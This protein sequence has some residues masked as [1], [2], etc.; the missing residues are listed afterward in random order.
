MKLFIYLT[1]LWNEQQ[2][3]FNTKTINT[4]VSGSN[5]WNILQNKTRY[6]YLIIQCY[7]RIALSSFKLNFKFSSAFCNSEIVRRS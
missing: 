4:P 2:I 3:Y 1:L 6:L 7:T 5:V